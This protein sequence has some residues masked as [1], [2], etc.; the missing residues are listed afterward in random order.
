MCRILG[1]TEQRQNENSCFPIDRPASNDVLFV[2]DHA[3][4]LSVDDE[5]GLDGKIRS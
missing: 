5:K 2:V 1:R 3:K 4:S